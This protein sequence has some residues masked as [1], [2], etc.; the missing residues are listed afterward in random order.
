MKK[1]TSIFAFIFGFFTFLLTA[2]VVEEQIGELNGVGAGQDEI[3]EQPVT[4]TY[5]F[6]IG[7]YDWGP[8]VDTVYVEFSEQFDEV[9]NE[10]ITV[11]ET[12]EVVV[13]TDSSF[14]VI[15]ETF[16]FEVTK[17]YFVDANYRETNEPTKTVGFDISVD[18]DSANPLLYSADSR[19]YVWSDPYYL[20]FKLAEDSKLVVRGAVVNELKIEQNPT[21][22]ETVSDDFD[23][24]YFEATDGTHYE[25]AYYLPEEK[26]ESLFVWLHG[27][28]EGAA[29]GL[30]NT[31]ASI[32]LLAN[33]ASIL[34]KD[35]FQKS[36]G[37]ANILVPQSPTMWM[38]MD[39]EGTY[40]TDGTSAYE[41]SLREMINYY[42]EEV[43]AEKVVLAG[44]S[45]GGYMTLRLAILYPHDYD[46]VIP[47]CHGYRSDWL[48]DDQLNSI[49]HIPMYFIYA[50]EDDTLLP[51]EHSIPSINRLRELGA[52][53]I[54]VSSTR[55]VV[56]TSKKY[57]DEWDN[58]YIYNPHWSWIYFLNNEAADDNDGTLIFNWIDRQFN[59]E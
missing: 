8:A 30:E 37:N 36:V 59:K 1:Y 40:T 25:Y 35:E 41:E 10:A 32:P 12:K 47:I 33:K 50:D 29:V 9:P 57:T 7:G 53:D 21:N 28:T 23:M 20:S 42:K 18:P 3:I 38:D 17:T 27:G 43:G 24:D 15:E 22:I 45:N 19:R 2:C 46:A 55:N 11:S 44:P 54:K 5:S 51:I 49:K 26:S 6:H 39:G 52:D 4:G 16:E 13:F 56:D 14:S 58:P 31:D 48:T 34:S